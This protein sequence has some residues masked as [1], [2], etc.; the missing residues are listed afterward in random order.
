[1]RRPVRSLFVAVLGVAIVLGTMPVAS[2]HPGDVDTSFGTGGWTGITA[3][4]DRIAGIVRRPDASLITGS[5]VGG[6]A[7]VETEALAQNGD[8]LLSYGSGGIGSVSVP[9]A[10]SADVVDIALQANDR[11]LL[12]G[13]GTATSGPDFFVVARFGPLGH[14]DTSFSGDG[15]A[16]IRFPH[17]AYGYGLAVQPDGKIVVV[18]EVDP[19]KNVSNPAVIRLNPNGTLDK[20]FGTGG[21]RVLKVPDHV[22][23]YD[24]TWRVAIAPSGNLVMAGWQQR[25]NHTYKTLA[26][27][28]HPD[29]SLDRSFGGDGS[30]IVDVDGVDNYAYGFALDGTK[31]VLGL[32]VNSGDATFLRLLPSGLRDK[33][34][35][36]DGVARHHEAASWE[37]DAVAVTPDHRILGTDGIAGDPFV[38]RLMP[39]G[40]L[41]SGFGTNGVADGLVTGSEGLG[42]KRLPTGKIVVVGDAG[43]QV[44]VT[45]FLG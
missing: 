40:H 17:N 33:T 45:R 6:T 18:G 39:G 32:H 23:G 5:S 12:A 29:V 41:D 21:R 16:E 42:V 24:G 13:W 14:P 3:G 27:R 9:G 34:F 8:P 4:T 31:I 37:V 20:T 36:I 7:T 15:V 35:G 2:A 43:G 1:M 11:V 30:V 25:P 26:I 44:V 22:A 28:L 10:S 19:G 38:M